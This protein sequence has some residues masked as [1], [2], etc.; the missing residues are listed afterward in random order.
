MP[1]ILKKDF[2]ITNADQYDNYIHAKISNIETN[3][4]LHN[5]VVKHVLRGPCGEDNK[6]CHCMINGKCKFHYSHQFS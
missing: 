3:P 1:V 2:K 4:A 5:V 6:K